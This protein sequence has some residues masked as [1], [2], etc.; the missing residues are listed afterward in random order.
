MSELSS[1]PQSEGNV[2]RIWDILGW[3]DVRTCVWWNTLFQDLSWDNSLLRWYRDQ[4][5]SRKQEYCTSQSRVARERTRD[6]HSG[7]ESYSLAH[8]TTE[9]EEE[10]VLTSSI[11]LPCLCRTLLLPYYR[12]MISSCE[13]ESMN[14]F[15]AHSL[16]FWNIAPYELAL[17]I[18]LLWL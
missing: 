6:S 15:W 10:K 4:G 3:K 11:P 13:I 5:I 12:S 1:R 9:T 18:E 7:S 16:E 2:R 17:S 8:S 14:I